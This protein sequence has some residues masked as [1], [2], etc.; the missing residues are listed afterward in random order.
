MVSRD[1]PSVR[2]LPSAVSAR[3]EQ[4]LART[5]RRAPGQTVV[6][7]FAALVLVGTVLLWL[8]LSKQGRGPTGLLDSLF[9][10]T[11]AVCVVGLTVVDTGT[12]WS[13]FGQATILVLMQVGGLGIMVGASLVGIAVSRRLGLRTRVMTAAATRTVG[14][15]DVRRVVMGVVAVS[16]SIEGLVAAALTLRF[17]LGYQLSLPTALW[18]GV[19]HSVSAFNNAGFSLFTDGLVPYVSDPWIC[20]P[21]DIAI[22]LGGL[23][24]PVLFEIFKD[25]RRRSGRRLTPNSRLTLQATAGLLT[26]GTFGFLMTE[27]GNSATLGPL[28]VGS[29][30]LAAFTQGVVPRT[31]GFNTLDFASMRPS[32]LLVTMGLMFIG[33]ATASTAGGIKVGTFMVALTSVWAQVR[34]DD[35]TVLAQRTVSPGVVRQAYSLIFLFSTALFLGVVALIVLSSMTGE[36]AAFQATSALTTTGLSTVQIGSLPDPALGVLTVMMFIGRL[37][38]VYVGAA[39]ALRQRRRRFRYPEGIHHV[40]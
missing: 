21:I 20:L 18:D 7:G 29:R 22:I 15:S 19:F 4:R 27:W 30:M 34:G 14:L 11:S 40:G 37:G 32:T 33:G 3:V 1:E 6:F 16:L 36:Q 25:H 12:H 9:T 8:P 23:G 35:D 38:P 13:T 5:Q 24:F 26:V 2:L 39:F 28:G 31:A 10:A 17:W